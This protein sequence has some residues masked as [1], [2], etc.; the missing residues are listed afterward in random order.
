[1]QRQST[2][3]TELVKLRT[4]DLIKMGWSKEDAQQAAAEQAK[5]YVFVMPVAIGC[6]VACAVLFFFAP[7][8][9]NLWWE[10]P[11]LLAG[12]FLA[13]GVLRHWLPKWVMLIGLFA[14]VTPIIAY[15]S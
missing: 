7:F 12:A 6:A 2:D 15:F 10:I 13:V 3:W 5:E 9:P 1:M 11:T 4:N 8:P 14:I